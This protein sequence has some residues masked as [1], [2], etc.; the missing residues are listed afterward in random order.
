MN[1]PIL[2]EPTPSFFT[3]FRKGPPRTDPQNQ[4]RKVL[5]MISGWAGSRM[6]SVEFQNLWHQNGG[7]EAPLNIRET[8]LNELAT[9]TVSPSEGFWVGAGNKRTPTSQQ[10]KFKRECFGI[11]KYSV[12]QVVPWVSDDPCTF[13][14]WH[15]M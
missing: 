5:S 3:N 4:K 11:S 8:H 7:A 14:V 6:N 2:P 10:H 9:Q 13:R 12:T 15:E 1:E